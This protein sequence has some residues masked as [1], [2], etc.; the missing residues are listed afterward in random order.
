VQV[1][2]AVLTGVFVVF[3]VAAVGPSLQAAATAPPRQRR[4]V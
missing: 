1:F 4:R 2:V 3:G